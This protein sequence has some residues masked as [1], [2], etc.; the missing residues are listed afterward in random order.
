MADLRVFT[1]EEWAALS[2]EDRGLCDEWP[3]GRYP[4]GY[5]QSGRAAEREFG[6]RAV[7]VQAWVAAHGPVPEGSIVCHHCDNRACRNPEHLFI[8]TYGDNAR[9]R[10][11]K[12]R[13]AAS[14]RTTCP[15]NHVYDYIDPK[16]GSRHCKQCR[17]RNLREMRARQKAV[18]V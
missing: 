10:D 7:H 3:H 9:D 14:G 1:R 4:N 17:A 12:K 13:G 8:G 6:T 15:Q 5:G 11:D 2:P 18:T 16:T